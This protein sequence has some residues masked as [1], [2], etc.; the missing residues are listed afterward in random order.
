MSQRNTIAARH[1]R[2]LLFVSSISAGV[3]NY[4]FGLLCVHQLGASTYADIAA[5]MSISMIITVPLAGLQAAYGRDVAIAV[6]GEDRSA[7][8]GLIEHG[9][10]RAVTLQ[11]LVFAIATATVPIAHYGAGVSEPELLVLLPLLTLGSTTVPIASGLL[12]GAERYTGLAIVT[13][14]GGFVKF[15]AAPVGIA[16]AGGVGAVLAG[17]VGAAAAMLVSIALVRPVRTWAG[18]AAAAVR[19]APATTALSSVALVAYAVLSNADL[20]L[21]QV[22][23][24]DAGAG[25]YAAATI[26]GRGVTFIATTVSVILLTSTARRMTQGVDTLVPLRRTMFA[27]ASLGVALAALCAATPDAI[28]ARVFGTAGDVSGLVAMSVIALTSAGL[29]NNL[30]SYALAHRLRWFV[31]GVFAASVVFP[32]VSVLLVDSGMELVAALTSVTVA[33]IATFFIRVR[34]TPDPIE[35]ASRIDP[36]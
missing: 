16:I 27:V 11:V 13:G 8:R 9:R 2:T 31:T 20:V 30:L 23:L 1:G 22:V 26:A 5:V 12:Q 29:V 10:R 34:R 21:A 15:A 3:A 28:Y 36:T 35:L 14:I 19:V 25:N 7:L 4:A 32:V 18:R 17:V 24:T 6:G 33:C